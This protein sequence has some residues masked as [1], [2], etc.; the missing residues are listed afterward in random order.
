MSPSP[1][2]E[3]SDK[4]RNAVGRD[5]DGKRAASSLGKGP[6]KRRTKTGCLT[7][8]KRRIKCDEEKPFCKNCIK[9][10]RECAGY[11][12]PL[13]YKQH[14]YSGF[15]I[16]PDGPDGH[17][18]PH[19][20]GFSFN[21][22]FDPSLGHARPAQHYFN[23]FGSYPHPL[24]SGDG[25][26]PALLASSPQ[27]PPPV[28]AH[29]H[30]TTSPAP[31]DEQN[32]R[33]S[34]NQPNHYLAYGGG[35]YNLA[36][37][38]APGWTGS[39]YLAQTPQPTIPQ[40]SVVSPTSSLPSP[41]NTYPPPTA[42]FFP[43]DAT[44]L[45]DASPRRYTAHGF[46]QASPLATVVPTLSG[47][48]VALGSI[49]DDFDRHNDGDE[50]DCSDHELASGQTTE[51]QLREIV[52]RNKAGGE[53]RFTKPSVQAE[54]SAALQ[55]AYQPASTSPLGDP[56]NERIFCH[57]VE[58]TSNCMSI[59]ERA[60]DFAFQPPRTLW[61]FYLP[62]AAINNQALAHA[63][64]ALGGL[65][66][67]KLRNMSEEPSLKH[68]TYA[69]RKVGRLIGLPDRRHEISTLA[70]VLLLGFYE[71][72]CADHSRWSLHLEGAKK[73]IMEMDFA[74][75]TRVARSMRRRARHRLQQYEHQYGV[76]A[77][78]DPALVAGIPG[79][80]LNDE[81]WEVDEQLISSLTGLPIDYDNQWQP[82]YPELYPRPDLSEKDVM[83]YKTKMDLRWWYWKQDVFR[84]MISGDPPLMPY[85]WAI[86]CPPRGQI[87]NAH[88]P[89]ATF[90][91]LLLL[92]ARLINFGGNDRQRKI[93]A[94]KA[95]AGDTTPSS[96]TRS[97]T[98]SE[99]G[100][101]DG[102]MPGASSSNGLG[103]DKAPKTGS[104]EAT[105]RKGSTPYANEGRPRQ[106]KPAG[107]QVPSFQGGPPMYGMMPPPPP[108]ESM[109]LHSSF[110]AM[111]HAI[112]D[113]AYALPQLEVRTEVPYQNLEE[114]TAKALSAHAAIKQALD[115]FASALGPDF[116]P[117]DADRA[118]FQ[119]SPFG[120]PLR[121]RSS[122]IAC[123]WLNYYVGL[124]LWHRLHPNLPAA[125]MIAAGIT[126]QQTYEYTE[127]VGK[128]CAGLFQSI[129]GDASNPLEPRLAGALI[130]TTIALLFSGVQYQEMSKRGWTISKL[131]DTARMTGW[132]TSAAVAAACEH[133]W[134]TQGRLGKGPPYHRS[135][136]RNNKDARVNGLPRLGDTVAPRVEDLDAA[137]EHES[138]FVR[139]D[140]SLIDRHGGTRVHWALGLLGVEQDM[141][142]LQLDST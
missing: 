86:L 36:Q 5:K 87:G 141:D 57:F 70:T 125:A 38:Q 83:D 52:D 58:V 88:I 11:I 84:G 54:A 107:L 98:T 35:A 1:E 91:H 135:L 15:P 100:S 27:Y 68:F 44:H 39:Q 34:F 28:P 16:P 61:N 47:P 97:S 76:Q 118:N 129:P 59:F 134:E 13:V 6:A 120:S 49:P 18:I 101:G 48:T 126:A 137:S 3:D 21:Q 108:R 112:G 94:Q 82:N 73:L 69:L 140:R 75:T 65:H 8:R 33:Q 41:Y 7:C 142:K 85:E 29:P 67:A 19:H 106:A 20:D 113:P 96:T 4:E 56:R 115:L 136:D 138:K 2:A 79:P 32:R 114:E 17:P 30:M 50:D 53:A 71:V 139:H 10:K 31:F 130:E 131:H 43:S 9:S 14:H 42:K 119:T 66:V 132:Q 51:Q 102:S 99:A 60:P 25:D 23:P 55:A 103:Q 80:L 111:E 92:L 45:H 116:Q 78:T 37:R 81:D 109:H 63:I 122:E 74:T 95:R 77:N 26:A 127:N 128:I 22:T 24:A 90:D 110:R 123:I 89:Y 46:L 121:Y 133:A 105:K 104:H 117:V 64:L 40:Y 62:A 72:M 93:R 12:Q 124:I